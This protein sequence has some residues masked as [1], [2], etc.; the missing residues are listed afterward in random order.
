MAQKEVIY[1]QNEH[2]SSKAKIAELQQE[3]QHLRAM[4]S[5][6]SA[7]PLQNTN[8][9]AA[10]QPTDHQPVANEELRHAIKLQTCEAAEVK[11]SSQICVD[12][13]GSQERSPLQEQLN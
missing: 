4:A 1:L 3:V 6:A 2:E 11:L 8:D 5:K 10:E 7:H 12:P 13:L 9:I